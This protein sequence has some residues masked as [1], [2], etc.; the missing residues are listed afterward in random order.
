VIKLCRI[1]EW[2]ATLL[3]ERKTA[4]LLAM[5]AALASGPVDRATWRRRIQR[6]CM[7]CPI[8]DRQRKACRSPFPAWR[9]LG[10]G[11]YVPFLAMTRSPYAKGCWGRTVVGGDFGWGDDL[12]NPPVI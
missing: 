9:H 10:C 8:Y 1:D 7:Q 2:R 12:D 6:G 5:L 4:S 3:R 11:C